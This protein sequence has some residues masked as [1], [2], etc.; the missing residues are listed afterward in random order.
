LKYLKN[1]KKIWQTETR[2]VLTQ[3]SGG[4][5]YRTSTRSFRGP[6]PQDWIIDAENDL[7][8]KKAQMEDLQRRYERLKDGADKDELVVLE[9]RL[10]AAKAGLAAFSVI[11]PFDG[12]VTDLNAKAGSSI[13]AGEIAV[14]V[15][16]FSNWLVKTT[17]LTEIDV[18][19][20][21]EGQPVVVTFDALPDAELNG[22]IRSIGQNYSESQ[23]D[24]VY[25]V[26]IL[27]RDS[28]PAMRWGMTAAVTFEN[29]E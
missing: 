26:T 5:K 8:L 12:V 27:L 16:D 29:Q 9:A 6:V 28:H 22:E 23:G 3:T 18:V 11:A 1:E 15:A 10:Q 20:L 19:K 14:T 13:N 2:R 24:V 21:T 7:A 4:Y 17:D 25:K